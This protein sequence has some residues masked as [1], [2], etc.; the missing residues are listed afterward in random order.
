MLF[1]RA[2]T[3]HTPNMPG[4]IVVDWQEEARNFPEFSKGDIEVFHEAFQQF[5][6]G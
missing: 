4:G 3:K 6:A 1:L 2:T 5:D